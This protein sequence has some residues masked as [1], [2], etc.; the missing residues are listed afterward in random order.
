MTKFTRAARK[1]AATFI[2]AT[3]GSLAGNSLLS[4]DAAAWK[5]AVGTGLG[6]LLNL[7]YRW[8]ES[9]TKEA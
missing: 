3:A 6:A 4:V 5:I 7:A 9:V 2:F 1:A 8:A